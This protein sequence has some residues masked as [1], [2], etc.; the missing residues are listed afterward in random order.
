M[1]FVVKAYSS[2]NGAAAVLQEFRLDAPSSALASRKIEDQG[3]IAVSVRPV[4]KGWAMR[5]SRRFDKASVLMFCHE[6]LALL[7]AGM[8]VV[9]AM[10]ILQRNARDAQMREVLGAVMEQLHSG[11]PLSQ[12]MEAAQPTSSQASSID[13]IFPTLLV[14]TIRSAERTGQLNQ[15]LK[16]Y[17][18]YQTELNA[19]RDKVVAASVYPALL[20]GVGLLVILF[21][22]TYVVP[23]FS[24]IYAD[25]G[26]DHLPLLSRWLLQWGLLI[27][28]HLLSIAAGFVLVLSLS[29]YALTRNGV[30]AW[31]IRSIWNLPRI[32][33]YLKTYQLAQ[34]VRTLGMLLT[35]GIP[36]VRALDMTADLLPLP[37][38]SRGLADARQAIA[39]GQSASEA[40]R[41]HGLATDVGVRL[42]VS[43]ERSGELAQV[44]ERTA[45]FYDAQVSRAVALFSRLFE[46]VLMIVIGLA[47]GVIIIL[48][49]MPIFELAGS[50][51]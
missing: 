17:L 4:S 27:N 21:L 12:A 36:L 18:D 31:V 42:L 38:L 2:A 51:Q 9:E 6:L 44:M 16:R 7:Q 13:A 3:L 10:D 32:G 33:E 19:V 37:A 24:S 43:G 14:A 22:M 30:R 39:E 25:V 46:P 34:F 47:I 23:R 50:I 26:K 35:G 20:L 29:A 5:W 11:K 28:A 48:M 15:A 45:G 1:Q 49:Y 8:G 41:I 40:F